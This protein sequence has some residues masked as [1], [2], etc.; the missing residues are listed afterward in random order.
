VEITPANGDAIDPIQ[1]LKATYDSGVSVAEM[2][3]VANG[4]I[5]KNSAGGIMFQSSSKSFPIIPNDLS[6]Q[7]ESFTDSAKSV[8]IKGLIYQKQKNQK[9]Q[10]LPSSLSVTVLEIQPE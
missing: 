5:K 4:Q 2:N 9:K 6:K 1:I 7:L 8:T 3:F 10:T